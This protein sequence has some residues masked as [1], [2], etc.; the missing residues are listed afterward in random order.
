MTLMSELSRRTATTGDPPQSGSRGDKY[1][2]PNIIPF[3]S[4][5]SSSRQTSAP[6]N[7]RASSRELSVPDHDRI[8]GIALSLALGIV[9]LF[10]GLMVF[11]GDLLFGIF[12]LG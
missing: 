4:R 12:D 2:S 6:S 8:A 10:A 3:V 1:A 11:A 9:L 5:A 7:S